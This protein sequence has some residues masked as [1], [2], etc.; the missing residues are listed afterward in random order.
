MDVD[1]ERTFL[2]IAETGSFVGAA[3]RLNLTQSAISMRIKALEQILGRQLFVRGKAGVTLTAAGEQFHRFATTLVRVWRQARQEVALPPEYRTILNVGGQFSLWHRLLLKWTR[4]M[5][6]Q[7]PEIAIQAE[8]GPADWL[9]R[10]LADGLLDLA[11][12]YAPQSRPGLEVEKIMDETL[13]LVATEP[14]H[15]GVG[16]DGY[17]FIDWGEEFQSSYSMAFP[18]L[19]MPALSF[20]VGATALAYLLEFGGAGYFPTRVVQPHLESG[21][22]HPIPTAPVFS[23]PAY[24]VFRPR[25][26][27]EDLDTVLKGL[28]LTASQESMAA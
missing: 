3:K 22:L 5:R 19:E 25:T 13:V 9:M 28:R 11:L 21:K 18:E 20:G 4:W 15:T 24:A 26:I 10:Q 8:V 23:R 7:V 16:G 2:E 6:G 1:L 27:G 14:A 12:L 17:V